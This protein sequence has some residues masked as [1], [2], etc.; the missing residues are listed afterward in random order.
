[1]TKEELEKLQQ[2]AK[3]FISGYLYRGKGLVELYQQARFE[4]AYTSRE[5]FFKYCKNQRTNDCLVHAV[6]ASV[7]D[8]LF[9][10][11]EQVIRLMSVRGKK[12][13]KKTIDLKVK[14]GISP[15]IFQNFAIVND[16]ALSLKLVRTFSIVKEETQH[17][18]LAFITQ[19]LLSEPPTYTR[20]VIVMEGR[21]QVQFMHAITIRR[22]D[23][24]KNMKNK[25]PNFW[26]LDFL[27]DNV[28]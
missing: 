20:L 10:T 3:P 27:N 28:V 14:G 9:T 26:L 7:G 21:G 18:V 17:D 8:A 6:N 13:K 19:K 12:S 23:F 22:K 16:M 2:D 4:S 11:R 5:I 15:S 25:V 24:Q 1:M